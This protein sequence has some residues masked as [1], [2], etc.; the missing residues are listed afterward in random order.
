MP[1]QNAA[2]TERG[3]AL[4]AGTLYLLTFATS[5][6]TLQLYRPLRDHPDFVL[7]AG[8]ATGVTWGALLEVVL[9]VS[10]AGTAVSLFPVVK[11]HSERAALG[12]VASR[13]VEASLVLVGVLS[14]LAILQ[15]RQ[16]APVADPAALTATARALLALYDGT[17]LLGQS[18]MPVMS[19]L[20]LGSALYRS[21]LVP[22]VIPA[23]GLAGAP[24]LL[25]SDVAVLCGVY[26]QG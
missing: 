13:V 18:L 2:R 21:R 5:I 17:F 1:N 22:R 6:P 16:G 15:L 11:R 3:T 26:P 7:G 23:L 4:V 12:F 9:A 8:S 25:A 14:L 10:C 24:L 20:C 19:A